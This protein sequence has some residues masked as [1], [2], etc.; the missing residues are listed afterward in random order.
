MEQRTD[1][2]NRRTKDRIETMYRIYLRIKLAFILVT[3]PIN[4]I[5][6][7]LQILSSKAAECLN[8]RNA[9]GNTP[10]H[11]ACRADKQDCVKALL[12][13]GADVNVSSK[14]ITTANTLLAANIGKVV[15]D[16]DGKLH[17]EVGRFQVLL[18]FTKLHFYYS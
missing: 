5:N 13:A 3:S 11:V 12:V 18:G 1:K 17:D 2:R 7:F 8:Y 14:P 15:K 9:S 16:H 10:L 4:L 6:I